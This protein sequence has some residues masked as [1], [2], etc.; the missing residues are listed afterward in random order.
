MDPITL[1][2]IA[3]ATGAAAGISAGAQDTVSSAIKDVYTTLKSFLAQK[4]AGKPE[5]EVAFGST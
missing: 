5:A 4:F 2:L 3:M 1:I